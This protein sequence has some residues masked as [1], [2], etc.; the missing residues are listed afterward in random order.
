M[1]TV[2]VAELAPG[3]P[4]APIYAATLGPLPRELD[5]GLRE[6][7]GLRELLSFEE[8]IPIQYAQVTGNLEDLVGRLVNTEVL[9]P[10]Q[11]ASVSLATGLEPDTSF[12]GNPPLLPSSGHERRAAGPNIIVAV[13]EGSPADP[14]LLWNLRGAHGDRRA[15]PIGLPADQVTRET[16]TFLQRPGIATMFG[17]GGGRCR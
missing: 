4:W 15:M 7:A 9:S 13:S 10:R 2:E 16:L 14:A 5:T 12:L 3:D 6:F 1:R 8:I 11:L 17:F